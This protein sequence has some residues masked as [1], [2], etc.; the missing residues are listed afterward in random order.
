MFVRSD[1]IIDPTQGGKSCDFCD[2]KNM[3]AVDELGR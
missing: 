2:W 1:D 3:T